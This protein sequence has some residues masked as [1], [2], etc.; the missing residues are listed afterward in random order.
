MFAARSE[1]FA[2]TIL[3]IDNIVMNRLF[4]VDLVDHQNQTVELD[5]NQ[6]HHL[7]RVLRLS[8]GDPVELFDGDGHLAPGRLEIPAARRPRIR[9][10]VKAATAVPRLKPHLTLA[11]AFPKGSRCDDMVRALV[12]TGV[13][14]LIPLQTDRSVTDPR[15]A[16]LDR[17]RQIVIESAKQCRATHLL[18]IDPPTD[19]SQAVTLPAEQRLLADPEGTARLQAREAGAHNSVV[20]LVGPEGGWTEREVGL[21]VQ[22][23]WQPWKFAPLVLRIENAAAAAAAILRYLGSLDC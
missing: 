2:R 21:A 1:V 15:D 3:T 8:D 4:L 22:E 19:F 14:R 16:R 5:Q 7:I 9:V 6:S 12:Q 20:C 18:Q 10:R 17:L 11:A 13:D 23:G